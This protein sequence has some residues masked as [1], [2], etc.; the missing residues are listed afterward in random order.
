[1]EVTPM[2]WKQ[3]IIVV[4]RV[5]AVS[6]EL[7]TELKSRAESAPTAFTLVM[8][9]TPVGDESEDGRVGIE[10]ALRRLRA[11]G[12]EV[13]GFVADS[14]PIVAVSEAW[15]P[16]RYDEIV[17]STLPMRMSKWLRSSLPERI[18]QLTGAPVTHVVAQPH[19]PVQV[20]HAEPHE[21]N[22]MGPLS[23]LGWGGHRP[24]A[25]REQPEGDP[26]RRSARG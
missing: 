13:D 14:D 23:V 18:R 3:Q 7:V 11:E 5:T 1:V 12:L 25:G 20:V 26:A 17:V 2:T 22:P 4:A 10:T 16:N 15:D 8:P 9:A 21:R 6:D 24:P 19:H